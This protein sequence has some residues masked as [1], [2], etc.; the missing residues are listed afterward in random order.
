MNVIFAVYPDFK[1]RARAIITM[2]QGEMQSVSR[3]HKMNTRIS[4]YAELVAVD[5]ASG[6]IFWM[7]L[8]IEYQGYKIDNIKLCQDNRSAIIL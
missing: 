2:G 5:G 8:F 7:V 1:S 4:I 6:Y 3:K